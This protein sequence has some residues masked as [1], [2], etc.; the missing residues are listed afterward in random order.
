MKRIISGTIIALS[1]VGGSLAAASAAHAKADFSD[2]IVCVRTTAEFA[3]G[4]VLSCSNRG[5][6]L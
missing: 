4:S 1:V 2:V 6:R 3:D 5:G